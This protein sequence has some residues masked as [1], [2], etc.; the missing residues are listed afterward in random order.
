MQLFWERALWSGKNKKHSHKKS[1]L[2]REYFRQ[3]S[4]AIIFLELST[5][6]ANFPRR[7]NIQ[8]E[9]HCRETSK[10]GFSKPRRKSFSSFRGNSLW[11][12]PK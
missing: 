11:L 7:H 12:K 6:F 10:Y 1:P 5:E 3:E 9:N 8:K 2:I 4:V